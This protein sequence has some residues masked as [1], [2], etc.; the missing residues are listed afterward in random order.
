M[1]SPELICIGLPILY[2]V[3][4][5][6]AKTIGKAEPVQSE[7]EVSTDWTEPPLPEYEMSRLMAK[8][9]KWHFSEVIFLTIFLF[10]L[11]Y[12]LPPLLVFIFLYFFVFGNGF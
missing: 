3:A 5:F 12:V 9:R 1:P 4:H 10:I 7:E 6:L 8:P 2:L 11:Q